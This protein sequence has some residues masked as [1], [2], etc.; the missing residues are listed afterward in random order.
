MV[1]TE[2]VHDPR[3]EDQKGVEVPEAPGHLP[4]SDDENVIDDISELRK[5]VKQLRQE[6]RTNKDK[7]D[8]HEKESNI[9]G[10]AGSLPQAARFPNMSNTYDD[11]GIQQSLRNFDARS[12]CA[13]PSRGTAKTRLSS[14]CGSNALPHT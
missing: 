6:L 7:E 11:N 5:L 10:E 3:I 9:G 4:Q 12:V 14:R 2:Q 1:A 8:K 13:S